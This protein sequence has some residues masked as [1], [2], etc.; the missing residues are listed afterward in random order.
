[1]KKS[2]VCGVP[3]GSV[4]GPVISN[5]YI[6]DILNVLNKFKHVLFADDINI[7]YSSEESETADNIVNK[8]LHLIY[9]WL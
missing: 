4:L 1:M 8:E 5:L 3:Q 2:I 7:L 6:N 9:T